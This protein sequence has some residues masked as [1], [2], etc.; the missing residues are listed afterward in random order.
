MRPPN[1][2]QNQPW[3]AATHWSV[4]LAA[5]QAG[6]E[7]RRQAIE[8]LCAT[9]WEPL[10]AYLRSMGQE[11]HDA[12]DL[13]QAFFA[14]L[15]GQNPFAQLS[16][17]GGRFRSFL[18]KSLQHFVADQRDRA[19][20]VKRG[21]GRVLVSLDQE[22]AERHHLDEAADAHPPEA[23][24]ERR[25]AITLL[26]RAFGALE[27]EFRA[28]GKAALFAE[29][30]VFLATEGRTDDYATVGTHLQMTPGA[31]AVAV[32]RLR[33]RYG[34]LIRA[35]VAQ[36]VPQPGDIEPEVHYLLELLCQ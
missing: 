17:A 22:L 16:P 6:D 20:A 10:Y 13:A 3:F 4:V 29:L 14:H 19:R 7:R 21:G 8:A 25:W 12:E 27:R 11:A 35:E 31:V 36:T 32:H 28:S 26:N 34:E 23:A 9:Y 30:G 24:F 33:Q 1:S 18:L 2:N 15:L 5:G